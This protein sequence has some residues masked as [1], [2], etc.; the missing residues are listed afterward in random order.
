MATPQ[1]VPTEYVEFNDEQRLEIS[2]KQGDRW[3]VSVA[4]G[5]FA[6]TGFT[7]EEAKSNANQAAKAHAQFQVVKDSLQV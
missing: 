5:S 3:A 7:K 6:A 4:S 2:N 1:T